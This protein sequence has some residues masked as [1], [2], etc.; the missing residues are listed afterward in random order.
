MREYP[1]KI[2]VSKKKGQLTTT[3]TNGAMTTI[4]VYISCVNSPISGKSESLEF[5]VQLSNS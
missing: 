2:L 1:K 5:R 4:L 3:N